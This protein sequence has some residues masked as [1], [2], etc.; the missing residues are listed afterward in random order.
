MTPHTAP[1]SVEWEGGFSLLL[2][3]RLIT[4]STRGTTSQFSSWS[5]LR[6][7]EISLWRRLITNS[8]VFTLANLIYPSRVKKHI[9]SF[10][11]E[12]STLSAFM[13]ETADRIGSAKDVFQ[14]FSFI[15]ME[16]T[17]RTKEYF[18]LL[19]HFIDNWEDSFSEEER[20]ALEQMLKVS[21]YPILIASQPCL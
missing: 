14:N 11:R 6:I 17:I 9:A 16:K 4:R 5:V 10:C 1:Y 21:S 3:I 13:K 7:F 20:Y 12:Y 2:R 19:R 8:L 18:L 15:K